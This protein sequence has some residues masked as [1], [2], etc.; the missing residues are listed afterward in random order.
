MNVSVFTHTNTFLRNY[1]L[2]CE[3]VSSFLDTIAIIALKAPKVSWNF[4]YWKTAWKK[5]K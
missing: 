1:A 5:Y 3:G 4:G 2:C